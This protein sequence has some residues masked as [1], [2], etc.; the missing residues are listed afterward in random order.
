[1]STCIIKYGGKTQEKNLSIVRHSEIAKDFLKMHN[2][3]IVVVSGA[4]DVT[5]RLEKA[6]IAG[7]K[8]NSLDENEFLNITDPSNVFGVWENLY[9]SAGKPKE[10]T[11][12]KN[13]IYKEF[14]SVVRII[15]PR[16]KTYE[17]MHTIRAELNLF[18]EKLQAA[19]V[20]H[21]YK[22][23]GL[24]SVCINFDNENFPLAVK[25]NHLNGIVNLVETKEKCQKLLSNTNE[26]VIV[27]PGYGGLDNKIE[28]TLGRG[29]SDTAAFA[30]GYGF[31]SEEIA[32]LTDVEGIKQAIINGKET[33][34]IEEISL[35]EAGDGAFYGAKLPSHDSLEPLIEMHKENSDPLAYIAHHEK[36]NGKKSKIVGVTRNKESVKFIGSRNNI[37]VYR[38]GGNVV[39]LPKVLEEHGIDNFYFGTRRLANVVLNQKGREIGEVIIDDYAKQG[40]INIEEKRDDLALVGIIGEGMRTKPGISG[41]MNSRLSEEGINIYL[42]FDVSP[43]STGV[44]ILDK[45]KSK[46]VSCL[47]DEFLNHTIY[48][49]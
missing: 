34:T 12:L 15:L 36:I 19:L 4:G 44:V 13:N 5:D 25:G 38:I 24:E 11:E 3:T 20:N 48:L 8:H 17:E 14:E 16:I 1:M 45:D 30:Y 18:P 40:K 9:N 47:Y 32:I 27:F 46:A 43:F 6:I 26:R 33:R 28:K 39:S 37:L 22:K 49:K 35:D 41:K 2:K 21:T 31:N 23:S 10:L 42:I 7:Q 29:G